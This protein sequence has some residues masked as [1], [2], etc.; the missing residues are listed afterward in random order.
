MLR[1][2]LASGHELATVPSEIDVLSLKQQLSVSGVSRFRQRLLQ[3]GRSLEDDEVLSGDQE[4]QLVLQSFWPASVA[5]VDELLVAVREG[6][7]MEVLEILCR[8]QD[9]ELTSVLP[10][11]DD[12]TV[13]PLFYAAQQ[14]HV[15]IARLLLEAKADA[16]HGIRQ[17][18]GSQKGRQSTPLVKA[19]AK[20]HHEMVQL[21]LDSRASA[22]L[23]CPILLYDATALVV[24]AVLGH[25]EVVDT[26]LRY[27][28]RTEIGCGVEVDCL[29]QCDGTALQVACERGHTQ[30]VQLLL[31]ALAD[32]EKVYE[33][34]KRLERRDPLI[35]AAVHGS[36]LVEL[37]TAEVLAAS[38]GPFNSLASAALQGHLNTAR[39]LMSSGKGPSLQRRLL[40]GLLRR[41]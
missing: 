7:E 24:A 9:P 40:V 37:L 27:G 3:Q 18:K 20:G 29:P 14:G 17:V 36:P 32:P 16:D 35:S 10:P 13:A 33:A 22:D 11:G 23:V 28:A 2:W 41:P 34:P 4:L 15:Q 39:L 30:V 5:S 12:W 26:L 25:L 31:Q 19:A 38:R 1:V 6:R 8:P 21:L